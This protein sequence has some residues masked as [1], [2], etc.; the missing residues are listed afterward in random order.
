MPFSTSPV[1]MTRAQASQRRRAGGQLKAE[2][3]VVCGSALEQPLASIPRIM[4][5]VR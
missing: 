1:A 5:A 3:K 2:E 4:S